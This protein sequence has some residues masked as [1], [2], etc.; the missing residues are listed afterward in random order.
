MTNTPAATLLMHPEAITQEKVDN[1]QLKA[2]QTVH[3]AAIV[4]KSC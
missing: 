1:L 3:H 4:Q 2:G